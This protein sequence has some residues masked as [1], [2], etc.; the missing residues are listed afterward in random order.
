VTPTP[1]A[2]APPAPPSQEELAARAAERRARGQDLAEDEDPSED[3]TTPLVP[4]SAPAIAR[5]PPGNWTSIPSSEK[6]NRKI[7]LLDQI[8]GQ[9]LELTVKPLTST[10]PSRIDASWTRRLDRCHLP[11]WLDP[12]AVDDCLLLLE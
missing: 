5:D 4:P 12:L 9:T 1:P 3:A 11:V 6:I 2:P 8:N 7:F 10:D